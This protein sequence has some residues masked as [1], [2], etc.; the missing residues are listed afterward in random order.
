MPHAAGK[1]D[2]DLGHR[3]ISLFRGD[4]DVAAQRQHAAGADRCAVDGGDDRLLALHDGVEALADDPVMTRIG[5]RLSRERRPLLQV[6]AG[7]ERFAVPGQDDGPDVGAIAQRVEDRHRLFAE[8]PV[9]RVDRRP[10]HRHGGYVVGDLDAEAFDRTP[11]C[12]YP[13]LLGLGCLLL[14]AVESSRVLDQDP[15]AQAGIADPFAET[16]EQVAHIGGERA[17]SDVRP[18]GAPDQPVR[19]RLDQGIME[20]TKVRVVR[21]LAGRPA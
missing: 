3:Q 7:R 16:I 14:E 19:C 4:Q 10:S 5:A 8:L 11:S 21:E 6:G 13:F 18:I 17:H 20:R 12:S 1:P 9:L 2:L 15:P